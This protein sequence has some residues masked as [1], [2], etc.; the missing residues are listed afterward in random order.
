[1]RSDDLVVVLNDQQ[2]RNWLKRDSVGNHVELDEEFT[3]EGQQYFKLAGLVGAV[4][5]CQWVSY[6]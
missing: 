3:E 1:M 2:I 6:Q 4:L 5:K